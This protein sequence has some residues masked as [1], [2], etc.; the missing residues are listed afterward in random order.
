MLRSLEMDKIVGALGDE[1]IGLG[2]VGEDKVVSP[3]SLSF[4]DLAGRN[5]TGKRGNNRSLVE[6]YKGKVKMKNDEIYWTFAW[7]WCCRGCS[8]SS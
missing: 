6:R 3:V 5:G 2:V 8:T 1:R 4:T 7:R